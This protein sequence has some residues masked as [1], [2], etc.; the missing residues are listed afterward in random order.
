MKVCRLAGL[1]S[2]RTAS[3]DTAPV[4]ALPVVSRK[5]GSGKTTLAMRLE[6]A[7][8]AEGRHASLGGL[9]PQACS[10][11]GSGRRTAE[12]PVALPTRAG[13]WRR[14]VRRIRTI[15]GGRLF[16][17]AAPHSDSAALE[18]ARIA[19]RALIPRRPAILG[20]EAITNTL[21]F[22]RT[23][24]VPVILL[25]TPAALPAPRPRHGKETSGG[26]EPGDHL[27][28][29]SEKDR[30]ASS[31]RDGSPPKR[32]SVSKREAANVCCAS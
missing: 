17:D 11:N 7:S 14:A 13:R 21:A 25:A 26:R 23:A 31:S 29:E 5:G 3:L 19:A 18:A 20:P 10:A 8:A 1:Q 9:A 6:A 28:G 4:E 32:C 30:A 27:A 15:G 24:S 2:C 12:A 16:P 22:T